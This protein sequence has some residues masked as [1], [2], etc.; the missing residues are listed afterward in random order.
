MWNRLRRALRRLW[1]RSQKGPEE[2]RAA[3][4]RAR[5]WTEVREGEREA[6]AHARRRAH[7]CL[8]TAAVDTANLQAR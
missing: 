7:H 5:F 8:R 2:R 4:V 3:R 1:R 6:E